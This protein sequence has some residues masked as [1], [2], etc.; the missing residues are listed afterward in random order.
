MITTGPRRCPY[1]RG[2]FGFPG[3]RPAAPLPVSDLLE[4]C[5]YTD[6]RL[7]KDGPPAPDQK[8]PETK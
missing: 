7:G 5:K 6:E 4:E 2:F 1:A 8:R 3:R